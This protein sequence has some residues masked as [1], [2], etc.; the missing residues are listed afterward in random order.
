MEGALKAYRSCQMA[1]N[2]IFH[3]QPIT[4]IL[5]HNNILH[6]PYCPIGQANT[7]QSSVDLMEI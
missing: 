3:N 6:V 1:K 5:D 4:T 2:D 7:M